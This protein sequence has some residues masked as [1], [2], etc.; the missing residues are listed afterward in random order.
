VESQLPLAQLIEEIDRVA[1]Y[2][3]SIDREVRSGR[4]DATSGVGGRDSH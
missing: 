3:E 1:D 2:A 4:M